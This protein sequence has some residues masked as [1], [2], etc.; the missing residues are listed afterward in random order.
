MILIVKTTTESTIN[1]CNILLINLN[2]VI[3]DSLNASVL[4][5]STSFDFIYIAIGSIMMCKHVNMLNHTLNAV[6]EEIFYGDAS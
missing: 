1:P 3:F 2:C 6:I 5:N 4:F